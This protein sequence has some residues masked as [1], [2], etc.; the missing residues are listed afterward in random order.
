MMCNF[1]VETL[2]LFSR[3]RL[4]SC[5][6][7]RSTVDFD[8]LDATLHR[9]LFRFV[10]LVAFIRVDAVIAGYNFP[11][12]PLLYYSLQWDSKEV[13]VFPT[14][15]RTLWVAQ[16][17]PRPCSLWLKQE[18]KLKFYVSRKLWSKR[19]QRWPYES[20]KA[21]VT[22]MSDIKCSSEPCVVVWLQ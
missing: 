13:W 14:T 12:S 17:E 16:S 20:G 5:N 21:R 18:F 11:V 1:E 4:E 6:F 7:S 10:T 3:K 19:I 15:I 2:Q 8:A 22:L 9:L